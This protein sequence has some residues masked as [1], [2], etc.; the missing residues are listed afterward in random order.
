MGHERFA[1]VARGPD[2]AGPPGFHV[3]LLGDFAVTRDSQAVTVPACSR[4]VVALLAL[5]RRPVERGHAAAL[6]WL[7]KDE[8]RARANLRSAL[9]RLRTTAP[10]LVADAPAGLTLGS[11][12]AVDVEDAQ[13]LAHDL[14]DER[15]EV[16]VGR[17]DATVLDGEL[18]PGWYDDFVESERERLR[19]LRLHALESLAR[20]LGR[21]G[22][23]AR[24]LEAALGVVSIEPLRES[25][26]RAVIELHLAE[27]NA[28]EALRQYRRME[29]LL[30]ESLGIRPSPVVRGLVAALLPGREAAL[31][32][33]G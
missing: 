12:T 9:W 15:R 30:R 8:A 22:Q 27:G 4:R 21:G 13:R 16:D 24:A 31:T 23:V 32:A 19:Q 11:G 1:D 17:L 33:A 7:D 29:A 20:R 28:S 10:G 6:L 18:L 14:I 26:H 3:H 2:G 25:A 5:R